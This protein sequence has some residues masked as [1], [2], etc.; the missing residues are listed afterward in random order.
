MN[1]PKTW[2]IKLWKKKKKSINLRIPKN[3]LVDC[4]NTP[5]TMYISQHT[6]TLTD[7]WRNNNIY[8]A[9]GMQNILLIKQNTRPYDTIS[10]IWNNTINIGERTEKER[11]KHSS[12][13][14]RNCMLWENTSSQACTFNR[15]M[16]MHI[17]IQ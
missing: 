11:M 13:W 7:T 15:F 9:K 5:R 14:K 4:Y 6:D 16:L 1:Q 17:D 3:N 10:M 8:H 2:K 12:Y